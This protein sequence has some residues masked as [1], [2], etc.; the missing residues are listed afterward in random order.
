MTNETGYTYSD[1][2]LDPTKMRFSRSARGN[3]ILHLNG[4]EYQ[5]LNIRRAFPLE[6]SERYIGFFLADGSELG[7]LDDPQQLEEQS[8][9][10]LLTELAKIYFHPRILAFNSLDEEY[11]LLRGEIETTSGTRPL[12][13]RGFRKSVRMLSGQRAIIED[14]DGNRYIVEDWPALP[15]RIREILGL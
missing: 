8:R 4:E 11:G 9:N 12:A 3:L 7:L 6:H 13:I 15:Q 10:E 5:D 1:F 14:V 2:L